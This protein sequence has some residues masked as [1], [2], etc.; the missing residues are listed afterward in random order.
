MTQ[1]AYP[2]V[3]MLPWKK[4]RVAAALQELVRWSKY[5]YSAC[6]TAGNDETWRGQR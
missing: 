4:R 2:V 6:R 3:P 5:S 1:A